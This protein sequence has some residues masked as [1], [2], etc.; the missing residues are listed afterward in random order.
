M[1]HMSTRVSRFVYR[2]HKTKPILT[3]L[4]PFDFLLTV[5]VSNGTEPVVLTPDMSES[6]AEW[7]N[8]Q[9]KMPLFC[10]GP[11]R[12]NLETTCKPGI[13]HVTGNIPHLLYD[14]IFKHVLTPDETVTLGNDIY[15]LFG[16]ELST[17]FHK[18]PYQTRLHD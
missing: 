14:D 15:N 18:K 13:Y 16:M 4:L 6:L 1:R 3:Q 10:W 7:Y 5:N 2:R 12:V 11:R 17:A 9:Y 8:T